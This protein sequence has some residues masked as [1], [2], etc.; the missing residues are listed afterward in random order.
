MLLTNGNHHLHVWRATPNGFRR[1]GKELLETSGRHPEED[2]ARRLAHA[3]EGMRQ[4]T[5][6]VD[7]RAR[8]KSL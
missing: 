4:A 1:S 8:T 7:E 5:R 3:L 2:L 6:K